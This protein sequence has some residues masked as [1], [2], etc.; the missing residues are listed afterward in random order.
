MIENKQKYFDKDTLL[1]IKASKGDIWQLSR[2]NNID[3]IYLD[4]IKDSNKPF[5]IK[6]AH[7]TLIAEKLN[8]KSNDVLEN[9]S[10][11]MAIIKTK[12]TFRSPKNTIS[13]IVFTMI[14]LLT[15]LFIHVKRNKQ[16]LGSK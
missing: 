8:M 7:Q 13:F 9:E 11:T 3:N 2:L 16:T 5:Q 4:A 15:I 12:K 10:Q 6:S 1:M 14:T